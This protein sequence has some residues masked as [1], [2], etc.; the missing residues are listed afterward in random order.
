VHAYAPVDQLVKV[1]LHQIKVRIDFPRGFNCCLDRLI[2]LAAT[3]VAGG[4]RRSV[5]CLSLD[6]WSEREN[7]SIDLGIQWN[8]CKRFIHSTRNQTHQHAMR[9]GYGSPSF[10]LHVVVMVHRSQRLI[11]TVGTGPETVGTG[12]TGPYRFWFRPVPDRSRLKIWI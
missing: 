9:A 12:P 10:P 5:R 6:R 2:S 11:E 7:D 8:Q 4:G 1:Q 3:A